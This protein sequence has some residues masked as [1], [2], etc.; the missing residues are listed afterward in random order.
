MSW[1]GKTMKKNEDKL[2]YSII[3]HKCR[4]GNF[5]Y[6]FFVLTDSLMMYFRCLTFF[7][8]VSRYLPFLHLLASSPHGKLFAIRSVA[9]FWQHNE[10]FIVILLDKFMAYRIVDSIAV[11]HWLF[12]KDM[13]PYFSTYGK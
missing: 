7:I 11:I 6:D 13:Q 2:L 8:F 12:S 4:Y 1:K 10:Q 9:A 5:N 3:Q